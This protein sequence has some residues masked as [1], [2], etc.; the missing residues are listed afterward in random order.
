MSDAIKKATGFLFANS[1]LVAT[2]IVQ[3]FVDQGDK[4]VVYQASLFADTGRQLCFRTPFAPLLE[5]K[6]C[7]GR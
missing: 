1:M 2:S 5:V 4:A 6:R 7:I 3:A